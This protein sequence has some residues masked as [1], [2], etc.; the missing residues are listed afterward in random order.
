MSRHSEQLEREVEDAREELATSLEEL[1]LKMTPREIVE[2]VV[3]YARETPV[4]DFARNLARDVRASPLPLL[5]IFAGIAWAAIASALAQR[6]AN[7][8]KLETALVRE[9]RSLQPSSP[10]RRRSVWS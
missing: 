5:V 2:E 8:R 6:R 3:D 4:G 1:R 10:R 9:P 7:A